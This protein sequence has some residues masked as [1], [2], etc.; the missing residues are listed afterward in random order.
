MNV[1]PDAIL[2]RLDG[3]LAPVIE[4]DE[5]LRALA[6]D[7]G[8]EILEYGV[9][10]LPR[11]LFQGRSGADIAAMIAEDLETALWMEPLLRPRE[12]EVPPE[13]V[14][15]GEEAPETPPEP[16]IEK[17]PPRIVELG[18]GWGINALLLAILHPDQPFHLVEPD[19]KRLWWWRRVTNLYGLRN[20]HVHAQSHEDFAR[21]NANT[22]DVVVVKRLAPNDALDLGVPMLRENGR[23]LS[24]QRSDRADEVRRPRMNAEGLP[25]RLETAQAFESP[26]AQKR[27]LLC[28]GLGLAVL[29]GREPAA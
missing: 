12:V 1:T 17:I 22:C 19:R 21:H 2:R 29:D 6:H 4:N 8:E 20:L 25:V 26:I 24:F 16:T 11:E 5:R 14:P 18:N 3:G 10:V 28:V 13:P 7:M 9:T 23:V 15:D 27:W